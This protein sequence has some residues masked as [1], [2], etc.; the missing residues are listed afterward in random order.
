MLIKFYST[1]YDAPFTLSLCSSSST[2]TLG[3]SNL[4]QRKKKSFGDFIEEQPRLAIDGKIVPMS[5]V[6]KATKV[7]QDKNNFQ[8][9]YNCIKERLNTKN[10]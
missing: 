2:F 4:V 3:V 5:N 9:I 6:V 1:C 8:I 10:G 7:R